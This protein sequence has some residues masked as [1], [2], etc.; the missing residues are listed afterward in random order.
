MGLKDNLLALFEANKGIYFSGEELA[1]KLN[2]SRAAVWKAVNNL[3]GMGYEIDAVPNRG[4]S[5]SVNTDILSAQGI[6]KYLSPECSFLTLDVYNQTESTN[7]LL[8]AKAA[9]GAP[10]GYTVLALSQTAGR[11]RRGRSFY[12]PAGTG[13]YMSIL[14]RPENMLPSQA[15]RLTTMAAVAACEAIEEISGEK[16]WIKWVNDIYVDGKKVSGILTEGSFG[17]ENGNMDYV[18]LGIG[19]NAELPENGFPDEIASVAGAVFHERLQDG[20]NRL[21]AGFLNGFISY[22]NAGDSADYINKYRRRSLVTGKKIKVLFPEGS[23]Q[24]VAL[25]V[26]EECRLAVRFE[27]GSIEKLSSGEISVRLY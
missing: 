21:A 16:A 26:D 9:D 14:L 4:Y 2:V 25:D 12:S 11:G 5:L 10:D 18:V 23:R 20:K 24:A 6:K 7:S 27:D 22:Y 1:S 15:V 8:R 13:V 3:R 19:F 17:L